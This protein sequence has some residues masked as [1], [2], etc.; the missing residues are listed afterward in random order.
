MRS[1]DERELLARE[2]FLIQHFIL[3]Q[4]GALRKFL[5]KMFMFDFA[6]TSPDAVHPLLWVA[7]WS[8]VI[9]SMAFFLAWSFLWG[10]TQGGR[11]A[12][13]WGIN[14]VAAVAQDVCVIQVFR[15]YIIHSISLLSI[16]PQLRNIYRALNRVGIV[17]AQDMIDPTEVP[18][19]VVQHLSPACRAA[20]AA[21][22]A[23]LTGAKI[24]LLV[25]DA[26]ILVCRQAN[27]RSRLAVAGTLLL[28]LPLVVGL[29]SESAGS[30]ALESVLPAVLDG[31]LVSNYYFYGA[32]G[33]FIIVPYAAFLA[34]IVWRSAAKKPAPVGKADGSGW[35]ASAR[36]ESA[37]R[38]VTRPP[39]SGPGEAATTAVHTASEWEIINKP[40]APSGANP[41]LPPKRTPLR[42]PSVKKVSIPEEVR[43]LHGPSEMGGWRD[44]WDATS[45]RSGY[46]T[47]LL[48]RTFSESSQARDTRPSWDVD[49][50]ELEL[51]E[52]EEPTE[53]ENVERALRSMLSSYRRRV[54]AG[55]MELVDAE[56]RAD[57]LSTDASTCNVLMEFADLRVL[58][59]E[60]LRG[61]RPNISP[62][63]CDRVVSSCYNWMAALGDEL[64]VVHYS[65][66]V[67]KIAAASLTRM[68]PITINSPLGSPVS[69][70]TLS[71]SSS[72]PSRKGATPTSRQ[73]RE[74]VNHAVPFQEV[75]YWA[76]NCSGLLTDVAP[77]PLTRGSSAVLVRGSS[78]SVVRQ[79]SMG[80]QLSL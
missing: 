3:E 70:P 18:V 44:G 5:V 41:T 4:F 78:G 32:A 14:L 28:T 57:L 62:A 47:R 55:Q 77:A 75:R 20:R 35:N 39:A 68:K 17:F 50:P 67:A 76:E 24:L 73:E 13:N 45:G 56:E 74:V 38:Y 69:S 37:W 58:L 8:F 29:I 19:N 27:T 36:S 64:L 33:L 53:S 80:E 79:I 52:T 65:N 42:S 9:L 54:Q 46:L 23:P 10:A 72:K 30:V 66:D 16:Q 48:S 12:Q 26:D 43:A 34:L 11:T 63:E 71:R 31:L 21:D 51:E 59:E 7:A 40:V 60:Y 6:D 61:T 1:I 15:V 25:D 49:R 2:K 22:C